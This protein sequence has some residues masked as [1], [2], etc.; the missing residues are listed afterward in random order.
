MVVVERAATRAPQPTEQGERVRRSHEGY[1]SRAQGAQ[2]P[3][4]SRLWAPRERRTG[5]SSGNH[6][7]TTASGTMRLNEAP[8]TRQNAKMPTDGAE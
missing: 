6:P 5:H 2:R 4:S 3:R 1:W 7:V 8:S